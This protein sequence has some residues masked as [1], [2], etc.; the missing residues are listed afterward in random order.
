VTQCT[1]CKL[2]SRYKER[3]LAKQKSVTFISPSRSNLEARKR[4]FPVDPRPNTSILNPTP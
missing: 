2:S 1:D 4:F 3:L